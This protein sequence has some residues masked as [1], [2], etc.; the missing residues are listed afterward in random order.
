MSSGQ[1][2]S[3]NFAN[4]FENEEMDFLL[5]SDYFKGDRDAQGDDE[6]KGTRK[7]DLSKSNASSNQPNLEDNDGDDMD[8][9]EDGKDSKGKRNNKLNTKRRGNTV[10]R[11]R[12]R[13]RVLARKTRLRK[14]YFFEVR[15]HIS[16]SSFN[17]SR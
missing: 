1:S 2:G 8:E 9:E 15:P 14:K 11:R 7:R 5:L 12:E 17:R 4:V 10:D 13:N 16:A 6:R 3:Q